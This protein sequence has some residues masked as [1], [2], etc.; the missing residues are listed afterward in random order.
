MALRDF[1]VGNKFDFSFEFG[2]KWEKCSAEI[3]R[4]KNQSS[5][6][7]LAVYYDGLT[8]SLDSIIVASIGDVRKICDML[9]GWNAMKRT[10]YN[11]VDGANAPAFENTIYKAK[12]IRFILKEVIK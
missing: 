8:V 6:Y 11:H 5:L 4:D 9:V 12:I 7:T 3:V 10:V 1:K 2:T